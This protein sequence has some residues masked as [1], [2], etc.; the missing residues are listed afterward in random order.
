MLVIVIVT[1]FVVVAAAAVVGV[2]VVVAVIVVAVAIFVVVVVCPS[3]PLLYPFFGWC[4]AEAQ[5]A[6][7]ARLCSFQRRLP[8]AAWQH[9][10]SG[11]VC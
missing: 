3:L 8:A 1:H 7:Y 5:S 9:R 4:V 6:S 2:V 10:M 11:V